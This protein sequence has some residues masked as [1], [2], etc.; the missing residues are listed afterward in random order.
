MSTTARTQAN[1][2]NA[3]RSTGPKT[4]A[5]KAIAAGNAR[6]HGLLSRELIL[7]GESHEDYELLLEELQRDWQPS[8]VTENLLLER[9][10]IALWRQ[11][12]LVR[13]ET[14]E[15]HLQQKANDPPKTYDIGRYLHDAIGSDCTDVVQQQHLP[16]LADRELWNEALLE[17]QQC[18]SFPRKVP[19]LAQFASHLPKMAAA[20]SSLAEYYAMA[21]ED[22][23]ADLI[24]EH[25]EA[26]VAA[27]EKAF[28]LELLRWDYQPLREQLLAT[29]NVP[30]NPDRLSRYQAALDND[31]Y[32][33]LRELR[34][35]QSFRRSRNEVVIPSEDQPSTEPAQLK[36]EQLP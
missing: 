14:A 8:G 5:G 23:L 28:R 24:E 34:T 15:I 32:K 11:R 20:I 21:P 4:T 22:W 33:A 10:A 31:L 30:I 29:R 2:R 18:N 36:K 26:Y 27:L 12:R 35:Q 9:I 13:V 25:A 17:L 3:Q 6:R 7:P 19:D 16:L 1:R